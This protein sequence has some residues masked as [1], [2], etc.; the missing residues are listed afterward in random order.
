[1]GIFLAG[2][3]RVA[4][5]ALVIAAASAAS[6]GYGDLPDTFDASTGYVTLNASDNTGAANQSFFLPTHWS[7]NQAPHADTNYY[8]KAGWCLGT[9]HQNSDVTA[10]LAIDPDCQTFKGRTLVIAGYLWHLNGTYDFTFPDLRMLPNT[11]I[12]YTA[13]KTPLS[14]TMTVYGTEAQPTCLRSNLGDIYQQPFGMDIKGDSS[15]CLAIYNS[16]KPTWYKLQ[17]NLS[18]FHGVLSAGHPSNA[19]A[20]GSYGF[21]VTSDHVAGTVA[22]PRKKA[23][24]CVTSANGLSVGGLRVT[25]KETRLFLDGSQLSSTTPRLTVTNSLEVTGWAYVML[26]TPTQGSGNRLVFN[27]YVVPAEADDKILIRL[28]PEVVRK[29]GW[30]GKLDELFRRPS[31]ANMASSSLRW[32]DDV[33]GGKSLVLVTCVAHTTVGE[34]NSRG[35]LA[36]PTLTDGGT[37]YFWSNESYPTDDPASGYSSSKTIYT[38]SG[39]GLYEFPGRLLLLTSAQIFVFGSQYGFVCDDFEWRAGGVNASINAGDPAG[40]VRK[41][42]NG[43]A[44]NCYNVRGTIRVPAGFVNTL[45]SYGARTVIRLESE[46]TGGGD[47]T[48]QTIN[49]AGDYKNDKGFVEFAACNTNFT[50]KVKVS[51]AD[52]TTKYANLGIVVP[53]WEQHMRL[54]VSDERNLGGVRDEFAWDALLIEQYSD[55]WPLNDVTF[56]DGWNRGIAIGNIGRMHV[57]NGLTLAIWRPLNVNGNLVKEGGGTLALGGPLTFGGASQSATPT[58]GANLLTVMGGFIKPLATNA[59]DG[60]AITLTN[61]AALKVDGMSADAGLL[62]YGLVNTKETTAPVSL[63]PNQATLS[64]TVDFG[65]AT[66]PPA[67]QWTV[68]LVTL[69]TTKAEALKP[70]MVLSNPAPF[71]NWRGTLDIVANGDGTSTIVV[72]YK[73][74]GMTIL[75]R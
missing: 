12:S 51:T 18:D 2:R 33:D 34:T 67:V 46:L 17:G 59:F 26:H 65:A 47:M 13:I 68:G 4:S 58:A 74:A 53:N 49:Y 75:F 64:V 36:F 22:L 32:R 42:E 16:D 72:N 62:K 73:M 71:K 45:Q 52:N 11:Y 60:L 9:P 21:H 5:L 15:S 57:T 54:F 38:P 28:E 70:Q 30:N 66:E 39:S 19:E 56:T 61:N 20:T 14:G 50:G 37:D 29:G 1:M 44:C 6:G 24:L 48:V 7:D 35:S 41:D 23:S 25:E 55:L 40:P 8:V 10:Q 43:T 27:D 63:A 31:D 3:T 69:D